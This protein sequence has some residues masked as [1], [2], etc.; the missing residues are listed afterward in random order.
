MP[1]FLYNTF[2]PKK[3]SVI[4]FEKVSSPSKRKRE[5]IVECLYHQMSFQGFL[6]DQHYTYF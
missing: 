5:Q 6:K 4:F 3:S 1:P 2:P